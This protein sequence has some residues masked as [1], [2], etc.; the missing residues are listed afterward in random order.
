MYIHHFLNFVSM[1]RVVPQKFVLLL[2]ALEE[3]GLEARGT[4]FR[5][6]TKSGHKSPT[7]VIH[8]YIMSF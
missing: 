4:T 1:S 5:V 7:Y 2:I 3:I 8:P 6:G